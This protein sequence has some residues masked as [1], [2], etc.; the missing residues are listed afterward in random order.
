MASFTKSA[1]TV[2]RN[3][4][5]AARDFR[6][7]KPVWYGGLIIIVLMGLTGF[8]LV[9]QQRH[10]A[11]LADVRAQE[12]EAGEQSAQAAARARGARGP[13]LRVS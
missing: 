3:P 11:E 8:L 13:T 5:P 1:T 4:L 10:A 2:W 12:A 7:P 9:L 6:V